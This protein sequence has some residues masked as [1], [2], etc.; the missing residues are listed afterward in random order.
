LS[1]VGLGEGRE[2]RK[3]SLL[4]SIILDEAFVRRALIVM[5]AFFIVPLFAGI[6]F[7]EPLSTTIIGKYVEESAKNVRETATSFTGAAYILLPLVIFA[8]NALVAVVNAVLSPLLVVPP[9]ILATNGLIVGF[10]IKT[11][12]GSIL[13]AHLAGGGVGLVVAAALS[14]HGAIEIP[15]ISISAS[16]IFYF[17]DFIKGR[18]PFGEA[19]KR[20]LLLAVTMLA[21]SALIETFITPVATILA[22]IIGMI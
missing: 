20:N 2:M 18:R 11:A 3:T 22:M 10:V 13:S 1:T 14:P 4:D 19:L 5:V 12:S 17:I 21:F 16:T 6:I 9:L 7:W 15:A 8:R